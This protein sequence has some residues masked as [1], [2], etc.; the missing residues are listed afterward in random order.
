ML[1][2]A[3]GSLWVVSIICMLFLAAYIYQLTRRQL[4]AGNNSYFWTVL[5]ILIVFCLGLSIFYFGVAS[6]V[7]SLPRLVAYGLEIR[8]I[9][10]WPAQAWVSLSLAFGICAILFALTDTIKND[11]NPRQ[12]F[13]LQWRSFSVPLFSFMLPYGLKF[14]QAR[15]NTPDLD[16][17]PSRYFSQR[18]QFWALA[19]VMVGLFTGCFLFVGLQTVSQVNFVQA[20][21]I[22]R[23]LSASMAFS[24]RVRPTPTPVGESFDGV[25]GGNNNSDN[26]DGSDNA[27]AAVGLAQA[28]LEVATPSVEQTS[29]QIDDVSSGTTEV[30]SNPP[31][32]GESSDPQTNTTAAS[33]S[34]NGAAAVVTDVGT[35]DSATAGTSAESAQ[36]EA[37]VVISEPLGVNARSGPGTTFGVITILQN[38]TRHVLLERSNDGQWL[39]V[40]LPD[41][42]NGWVASWVVDV[43]P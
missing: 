7:E 6:R 5:R 38:G 2:V 35:A 12:G 40:Q 20:L 10:L 19:N 3:I 9:P 13:R 4:D 29:P 28:P 30:N 23:D 16:N 1:Y 21:G 14:S 8:Q 15:A 26:G 31:S 41:T 37:I 36:T 17:G 18:D 25:L 34:V 43:L 27:V 11:L 32:S 24:E 22:Q 33:E 42:G 39:N